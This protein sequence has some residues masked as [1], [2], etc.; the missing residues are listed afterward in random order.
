MAIAYKGTYAYLTDIGKVRVSNEDQAYVSLNS[1]GEVFLIVCDGMGGQNKGDYASKMAI[2]SML[3][4]FAQ[5]PS[6]LPFFLRKTWITQAVKKA[7]GIIFDEADKNAIY[8]DMGTTL[9]A[10]W[11]VKDRLVLA[12]VGDSRC[13]ALKNDQLVRY[14]EDQTYV[15]YLYRTGKISQSQ[16]LSHPERHVLMNAL[17]IYPSASVDV[18]VLPY[19]G[20]S[21]LLCSDGLYN[22]VAENEIRALIATDERADQKALSLINEA[23][24]NGGSDNIGVAYWETLK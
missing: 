16:T 3:D 2:D 9:V 15:D 21:I 6:H 12:N 10:A 1:D 4:S 17:G 23:N 13:Y 19:H 22:N 8:K 14:S 5:K 24:N 18:K 11:I 7:N 20:E